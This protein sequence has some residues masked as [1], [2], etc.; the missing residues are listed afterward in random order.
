MGVRIISNQSGDYGEKGAVIF[1]SVSG[2]AFGPV[3]DDYDAAQAFLDWLPD[4][5]RRYAGA[6]LQRK[7]GDW[8]KTLESDPKEVNAA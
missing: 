1:D 5:A 6:D 4:D 8:L 3:F 7:H 2:W